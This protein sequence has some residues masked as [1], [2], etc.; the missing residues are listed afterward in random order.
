VC[1]SHHDH[2]WRVG[3]LGDTLRQ[4][5]LLPTAKGTVSGTPAG[6]GS[7]L[8]IR[9]EDEINLHDDFIISLIIIYNIVF[10][11]ILQ[12]APPVAPP[13]INTHDS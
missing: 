4:N 1:F 11:I 3:K 9:F 12:L 8:E 6:K 10:H 2:T 7:S 13:H 5:H